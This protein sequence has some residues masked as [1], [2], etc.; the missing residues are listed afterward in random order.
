MDAYGDHVTTCTKH[1]KTIMHN[2]IRNDIWNFLRKTCMSVKLIS[3]EAMV[4]QEPPKT[5]SELP[6][7]RPFD[8]LAI[9][10]HMLDE[11]KY[12][13]LGLEN[14]KNDITILSSF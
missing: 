14:A 10:D 6:R 11:D 3:S 13:A 4:E 7:L 5:A 2:S 9:F 12:M 1:S 8:V